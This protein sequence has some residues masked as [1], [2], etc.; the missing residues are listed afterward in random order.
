M[1]KKFVFAFLLALIVD[2]IVK[3]LIVGGLRWN[4]EC[5][6]IVYVLND[7]VAFSMFAFL[8]EYLKY[9]QIVVILGMLVYLY[10]E[11]Y[12][13]IYSIEIGMIFGSGISNLIDRFT[14]GG[15]VDYVYWHCW[16]D[17]AIFNLA[18]ILIDVGIVSLILRVYIAS[19][20]VSIE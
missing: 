1:L 4:S 13:T 10:R 6:S 17:F 18:D 20:S 11:N 15:V 8:K 3:I 19:R 16:F 5:I 7:G 14:R 2:Q 9:F 12:F